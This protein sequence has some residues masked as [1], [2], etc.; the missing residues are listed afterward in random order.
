MGHGYSQPPMNEGYR[1]PTCGE[2]LVGSGDDAPT[3]RCESGHR[4]PIVGDVPR[5]VAQAQYTRSF[6]RQWNRWATTQLDSQNGT[7]I[8][9]DRFTRYFGPPEEL[10]GMRVLDAGCGAGAFVDVVAPH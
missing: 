3:L 8:F 6:G 4:F 10:R 7:T 1:C 2:G 5:F 9:H